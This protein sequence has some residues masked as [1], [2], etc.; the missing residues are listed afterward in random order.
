MRYYRPAKYHIT[1]FYCSLDLFGTGAGQR[2]RRVYSGNIPLQVT[3]GMIGIWRWC[4]N[5]LQYIYRLFFF[6]WHGD[7]CNIVTSRSFRCTDCFHRN[8]RR[9]RGKKRR[10]QALPSA[11]PPGSSLDRIAPPPGLPRNHPGLRRAIDTSE[12]KRSRMEKNSKLFTIEKS[13]EKIVI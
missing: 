7:P 9:R 2:S 1:K 5:D 11:V 13:N 4:M 8:R 10:R 6:G 12:W 3:N